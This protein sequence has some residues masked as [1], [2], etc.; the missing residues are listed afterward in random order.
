VYKRQHQ[1]REDDAAI[2]VRST[3]RR[4]AATTR[5]FLIACY[6]ATLLLLAAAGWVAGLSWLYY[7]ALLLPA[8]ML[9][10]QV[11]ALDIHNP[12]LCLA[13]FKANRDVGLAVALAIVIG[14][15]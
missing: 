15:W 6:G 5:P 3:A 1:D 2:G 4:F 12:A 11:V 13:L 10:R 9:G 8:V 7:P 14:R